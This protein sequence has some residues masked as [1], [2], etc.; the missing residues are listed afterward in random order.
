VFR[1]ADKQRKPVAAA[2]PGSQATLQPDG[3]LPNSTVSSPPPPEAN[4]RVE[5]VPPM[6]ENASASQEPEK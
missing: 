3:H 4:Q 6:T 2:S 5:V 1:R